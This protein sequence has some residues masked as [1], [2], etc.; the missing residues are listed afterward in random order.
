MVSFSGFYAC[1]KRNAFKCFLNA[2]TISNCVTCKGNL[3]NNLGAVYEKDRVANKRSCTALLEPLNWG[4]K[5]SAKYLGSPN[6]RTN[7]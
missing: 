5:I 7:K 4:D 6:L 1:K 2:S 3:L